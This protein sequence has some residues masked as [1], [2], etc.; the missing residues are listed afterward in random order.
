M[1]LA[2]Q[3]LRKKMHLIKPLRDEATVPDILQQEIDKEI[4]VKL[5]KAAGWIDVARPPEGWD[6][7]AIESWCSS[8]LPPESWHYYGR[9]CLFSTREQAILFQLTWT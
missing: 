7:D 3:H 8:N 1:D 5:R 6:E 4:L 9:G 2:Q